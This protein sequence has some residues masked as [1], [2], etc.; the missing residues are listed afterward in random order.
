MAINNNA[1]IGFSGISFPGGGGGGSPQP[2]T[3]QVTFGFNGDITGVSTDT[4]GNMYLLYNAPAGSTVD[5]GAFMRAFD[6]DVLKKISIAVG[7]SDSGDVTVGVYSADNIGGPWTLAQKVTIAAAPTGN[8]MYVEKAVNI[9]LVKG[10]YYF[11]G[12]NS[13]VVQLVQ[14]AATGGFKRW[15]AA[16]GEAPS[17]LADADSSGSAYVAYLY[18]TVDRTTNP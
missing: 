3:K 13:D 6:G 8:N 17:P 7:A 5:N 16:A 15:T 1:G 11:L 9:P 4:F 10:N 18:G 14:L 12:V 2:I